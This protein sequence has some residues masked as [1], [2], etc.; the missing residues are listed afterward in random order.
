[1]SAQ[2]APSRT[3]PETLFAD[4]IVPR[5]LTGPFTYTVPSSLRHTLRIGHRVLVP[6]GRSIL[7]GA[8]VGLSYV[9][10]QGLDRARLKEI[11]S[12]QSEGAAAE[13]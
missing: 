1:M 2:A 6:F 9:P 4:V 7:E 13:V 8:V 3:E 12:L 5:H 11:R 10:P